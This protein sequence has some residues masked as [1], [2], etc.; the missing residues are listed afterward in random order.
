M[1][2]N[3]LTIIQGNNLSFNNTNSVIIGKNLSE[4]LN[5]KTGDK[6]LALSVLSKQY[7]ELQIEGI[8]QSSSPLDDEV[9]YRSI[10]D[11]G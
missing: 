1:K 7:V 6:I 5:L 3:S 8:Y 4:R 2:L 9:L 11:N 10:L